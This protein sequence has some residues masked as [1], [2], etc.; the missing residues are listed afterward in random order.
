MKIAA[1]PPPTHH[2]E[3]SLGYFRFGASLELRD[4]TGFEPTES[5]QELLAREIVNP[6]VRED[7]ERAPSII[8]AG[9]DVEEFTGHILVVSLVDARDPAEALERLSYAYFRGLHRWFEGIVDLECQEFV[10]AHV[11]REDILRESA[12]TTP[13]LHAIL[14][15]DYCRDELPVAQLDLTS[16]VPPSLIEATRLV[17]QA[18]EDALTL[19]EQ[20]RRRD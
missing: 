11:A 5:Q 9:I 7:D 16:E 6:T 10:E 1:A 13:P 3:D 20:E 4:I 19:P 12:P 2:L 18:R 8:R 14:S 17:Y 15:R